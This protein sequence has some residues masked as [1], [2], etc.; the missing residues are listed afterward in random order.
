MMLFHRG[1]MFGAARLYL[2]GTTTG[3]NDR[4]A[5]AASTGLNCER[6]MNPIRAATAVA[7]LAAAAVAC[8]GPDAGS[9][10][11]A[12][13]ASS[14]RGRRGGPGGAFPNRVL[15]RCRPA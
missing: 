10:A 12:Q 11:A 7:L 4:F 6:L 5:D 3:V 2:A 14:G 1:S 15:V 8:G 13:S 9:G